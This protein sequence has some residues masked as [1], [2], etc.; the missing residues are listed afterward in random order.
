M[1]AR[2]EIIISICPVKQDK[3]KLMEILNKYLTPEDKMM[4]AIKHQT[5]ENYVN[6]I[7]RG[8]RGKRS[9]KAKRIL[10]DLE[11]LAQENVL[12]MG[13]KRSLLGIKK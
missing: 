9:P 6:K 12:W 13:H 4:V 2:T 3:F 5:D 11:S 10:A 7:I 1:F 8:I